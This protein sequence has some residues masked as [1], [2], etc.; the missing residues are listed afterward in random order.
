MAAGSRP[1]WLTPSI[2]IE[3]LLER[4]PAAA[5][6]LSRFRIVCIAC[7]EPVWGTLEENAR[8]AGVTDLEPVLDALAAG[9]DEGA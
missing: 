7:G 8:Q 6:I 2:T 3:E 9:L 4:I 5:R 1:D